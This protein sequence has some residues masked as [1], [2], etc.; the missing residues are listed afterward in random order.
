MGERL[1]LD[2]PLQKHQ[3]V[4]V[5]L[6]KNKPKWPPVHTQTLNGAGLESIFL[7]DWG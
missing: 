6:E 4:M 7:Q 2:S 1:T 5:V 3:A